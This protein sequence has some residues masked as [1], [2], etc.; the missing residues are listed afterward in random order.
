MSE[1][2]LFN[3]RSESTHLRGTNISQ[4]NSFIQRNY[5]GDQH[6]L[7]HRFPHMQYHLFYYQTQPAQEVRGHSINFH[8]PV[9]APSYRVPANSPS[10]SSTSIQNAPFGFYMQQPPHHRGNMHGT[11]PGHWRNLPPVAFLQDDYVPSL[12][13]HHSDLDIEDMSY[14]ELLV[15]DEQIGKIGNV[16]MGLL[17]EIITREMKTKTCLLPNNLE[18]ATSEEQETEL[19]IICQDEYKNKEELGIL[20]CGHTYH[21]DCIRR[22]LHEKNVCPMCKSKVLDLA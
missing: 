21:A 5:L 19:C 1:Q 2:G 8:P 20:Q 6:L 14:E 4:P 3:F 16:G 7:S 22:W 9:T 11:A 15:L 18:G 10:S 12:G 17:Q 13:D